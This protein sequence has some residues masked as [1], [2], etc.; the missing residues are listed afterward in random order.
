MK[1]FVTGA[2]GFVG[3]ATTKT[4]IANG[5]TVLGLARSDKSASNLESLG[6][7]VLRGDLEDLAS[8]KKG[9]QQADATVHL[10]F[11]HDFSDMT[12]ACAMDKAAIEAMAEVLKDSGKPLVIASGTLFL[13][14]GQVATEDTMPKVAAEATFSTRSENAKLVVRLGHENGFKGMVVRLAP[15]VHGKGDHGMIPLFV[16]PMKAAGKIV[17]VGDGSARWTAVHV[18]DAAN[19]FRLAVERG[20]SGD[21]Y[22]GVAESGVTMAEI[23]GVVS[24]KLGLELSH[25]D[26]AGA[27][28]VLGNFAGLL[29]TDSPA[30]SKKTQAKLGWNPTGVGL[31]ED[32]EKNYH[33]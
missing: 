2:P 15:T 24:K 8:L 9:A 29:A 21:I 7:E 31:L 1:V 12:K 6:A 14:T 22:H 28:V 4:L 19:L 32:L 5:H 20:N 33:F 23:F 25:E 17:V 27:G 30:T 26:F 3:T 16:A 13:A 10:A 11:H 18:D